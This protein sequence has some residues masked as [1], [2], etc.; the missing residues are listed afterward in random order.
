MWRLKHVAQVDFDHP[1]A[2]QFGC[3]VDVLGVD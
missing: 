2:W 3:V 1:Q